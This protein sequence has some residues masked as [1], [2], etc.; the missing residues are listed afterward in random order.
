MIKVSSVT[1]RYDEQVVLDDVTVTIPRG[2]LTALV[3][4][5]GAGK[6]T[7]L[8]A[9][10]RLLAPDSGKVLIDEMD[11]QRTPSKKLAKR[12]AIL[13]QENNLAVRLTV[14]DLVAFGRHPHSGGRL[15]VEDEKQIQASMDYLHLGEFADRFLDEISGGQRQRAFVAMVL[16]QDTEYVL[17][18]EP[19]NNLDLAH[20]VAIMQLL[21]RAADD[22]GK[23][24]VIVVHDIN[25]A[26]AYADHIIA[27][28]DGAIVATG[29]AREL[30]TPELLED[31][32][33]VAVGV[34][35]INGQLVCLPYALQTVDRAI[36]EAALSA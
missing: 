12:L 30:M 1:K 23:T 20:A 4:P 10:S 28:R 5:N 22:L 24:I 21:R 2:G 14:R 34:Q 19:L 17:L 25:A 27:M 18:D 6:S 16:C 8:S 7:L 3:G 33:G 32:F 31:V 9:M 36:P 26:A 35:E 13:R 29:S 11:V 15:T